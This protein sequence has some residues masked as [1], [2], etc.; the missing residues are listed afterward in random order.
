MS[1]STSLL[2]C[3]A[4]RKPEALFFTGQEYSGQFLGETDLRIRVV[5]IINAKRHVHDRHLDTH[6]DADARFD[7]GVFSKLCIVDLQKGNLLHLAS[8]VQL[9]NLWRKAR[10]APEP[11][12]AAKFIDK[13]GLRHHS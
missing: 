10:R 3:P 7:I 5:I 12:S 9:L 13:I 6:L 2:K 4:D 8:Q 11:V 1:K